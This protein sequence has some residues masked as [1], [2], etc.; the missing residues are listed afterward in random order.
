M[1]VASNVRVSESRLAAI[2][3]TRAIR[4]RNTLVGVA[5][6]SACVPLAESIAAA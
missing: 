6:K 4:E 3:G 1:N 2:R 5:T